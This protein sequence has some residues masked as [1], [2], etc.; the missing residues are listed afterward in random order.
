MKP[1]FLLLSFLPVLLFAQ[2]DE[3]Y[4]AGAVPE[5]NGKVVF[6]KSITAPSLSQSQL[7]HTLLEW[8]KKRFNNARSRLV[9]ENAEK[10]EIAA[11]G[12]D[13]LVFENNALSLDRSLMSY[14][15]IV[16][17]TG[18]TCTLSMQNIRYEYTVSYQREPERYAAEAWISDKA[19]LHKGKLARLNGKFRIATIDYAAHLLDEA[20]SAVAESTV[21]ESILPPASEN[22]GLQ[23]ETPSLLPGYRQIPADKIPGNIISMLSEDW[24]LITAGNDASFNMM[25]AGWGGLGRLL[26]KP[27]AF[28]FIHPA[29]YTYRFM[30]ENDTFTLSFYAEAYREAL[31]YCGSASGRDTD[32]VKGSGLSPITTPSGSMAF[33]EAR[34]IIECRKLISQPFD[35][36]VVT[37]EKIRD[38]WLGKQMH[39]MYIGEIIHVWMK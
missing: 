26:D 16:T 12:E 11:L 13:Y 5:E 9:Y 14:Q 27:V 15:L 17:C 7:H 6:S 1:L 18:N 19:A 2:T 24:A 38:E 23:A 36:K 3:K 34:M 31:Q 39:T 33:S 32:K 8:T 25:T 20:E 30:E 37:D 21:A 35:A 10:G 22:T 4:V 29:R 28:C